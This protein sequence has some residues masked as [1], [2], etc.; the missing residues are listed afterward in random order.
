MK[1]VKQYI[2][3]NKERFLNELFDLI[4]IP[5]ISAETEHKDDMVR[6]ANKWKEYLLAAGAARR[7]AGECSRPHQSVG[8]AGL[9]AG[10][11]R[12]Q[13]A[14]A[15]GSGSISVVIPVGR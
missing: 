3:T 15:A 1:D 14:P 5:S 4:R 2:E 12:W 10:A 7:R 9:V 13:H 8:A 6:C 11:L